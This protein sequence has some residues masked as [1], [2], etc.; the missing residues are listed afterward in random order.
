LGVGDGAHRRMVMKNGVVNRKRDKGGSVQ[1]FAEV[2]RSA[3][4]S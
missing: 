3:P 4:A 1:S 2:E